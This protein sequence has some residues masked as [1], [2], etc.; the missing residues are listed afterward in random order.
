MQT[1]RAL[2]AI[3]V[4][5][6]LLVGCAKGEN[7]SPVNSF[8]HGPLNTGERTTTPVPTGAGLTPES[9]PTGPVQIDVKVG[10]D[11]SPNRVEKVR[12]G[13]AV[14]LNITNPGAAEDYHVHVVDLEQKVAENVT[15]T[16][17]FTASAPGRYEVESHVTNTV[18][19]V[20]DVA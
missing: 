16:F 3:P 2:A 5:A 20:I 6:V 13:T 9:V 18:L 1:L 15:A 17:N 11:S 14:T 12:A 10:T 19:L 7:T 8:G 4:A